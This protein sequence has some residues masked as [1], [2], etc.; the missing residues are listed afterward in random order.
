MPALEMAQETGKLVSW[1]KKEGDTVVKGEPLLEIETD[2]AVMEIES[3][4]DGILAAIK[5]QPGAEV[6]VG[7][8]IAWIVRAG[9][10]PPAEEGSGKNESG[11]KMTAPPVA[12]L[13]ATNSAS[14]ETQA[15][16][17]G[18][19]NFAEGPPPRQRTWR[20]SCWIA[21]IRTRR[22]N[23]RVRHSRRGRNEN[24][25]RNDCAR[26]RRQC[27]FATDGGTYYAKLDHRPA[28]LRRP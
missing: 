26:R 2:K 14:V 13:A 27:G 17:S 18:P 12:V 21:R 1:L 15:A 24:S 22:R 11:R 9:E 19:T 28:F 6:A 7:K 3:P 5:A 20:Q 10:T 23:S 4:G 25:F 16:E 8:T